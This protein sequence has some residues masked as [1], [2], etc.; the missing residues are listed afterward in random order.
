M[1]SVG[2]CDPYVTVELEGSSQQFTTAVQ[3]NT[4]SPVW[5]Q[6]FTFEVLSY[7]TDIIAFQMYDKDVSSDDKMGKLHIQ[8]SLLPPGQVIDQW[9]TLQPTHG[10]EQP[11]EIHLGLHVAPK[12]VPLWTVA[13]FVPLQAVIVLVEANDL[14]KMDTFGKADP[15]CEINLANTPIVFTSAAKDCTFTPVWNEAFNFPLTN[16]MTDKLEILMKDKDMLVDESMANLTLP[17]A[18]Y[19]NGQPF[20]GWFPMVPVKG[21][22]KGGN[23]HLQISLVPANP[24]EYLPTQTGAVIRPPKAEYYSNWEGGVGSRRHG[25]WHT[26]HRGPGYRGPS[27]AFGHGHGGFG[28]G[29]IH[30][31]R[32][33]H[34]G[35]H[36]GHGGIHHGVGGHRGGGHCGGGHHGG[37]G[38]R[39]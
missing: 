31:G 34:G 36:G 23:L 25:R 28:H 38:H 15:Y 17:L 27:H 10:C 1:D 12:G 33:G 37:G 8:V 3:Q 4:D 26:V 39:R 13:P 14:A 20:D 30:H 9:Y 11:G 29:G 7:S 35:I 6:T 32:P 2:K 18:P 19:A 21:V 16:P 5:E 24:V 22:A